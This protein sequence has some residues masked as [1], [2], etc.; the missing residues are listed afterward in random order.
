MFECHYIASKMFDSEAEGYEFYNKY[1]LVKGFSVRKSYAE[2]GG[3]NNYVI[4]RKMVCS[5]QGFYE[6]K[7]MKRK[8]EDRKRR[9]HSLIRVG[10]N[11]KLVIARQDETCRWFVQDFIDEHNHA[12]A[13]HDL[14]CL[15]H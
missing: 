10:C 5:R 6:E 8:I 7:H 4:L 2:G 12:L 11:T 9:P 13:P 15:L 14:S 3:S 1:A